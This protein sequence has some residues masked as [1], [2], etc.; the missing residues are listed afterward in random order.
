MIKCSTLIS[1]F[2]QKTSERIIDAIFVVQY[3]MFMR[4]LHVHQAAVQC[5][6]F[7]SVNTNIHINLILFYKVI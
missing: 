4:M 3:I 6:R 7:I 2:Y 5:E 1:H